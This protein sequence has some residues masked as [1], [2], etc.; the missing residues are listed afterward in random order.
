MNAATVALI[1]GLLTL[2][3][4]EAPVLIPKIKELFEIL[5]GTDVQ[6]ITHEELVARVDAAI[7]KLPVWE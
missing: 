1:I 2:I 3:A 4:Q 5:R 6:D 7:A